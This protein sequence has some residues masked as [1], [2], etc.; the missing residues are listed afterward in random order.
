MEAQWGEAEQEYHLVRRALALAYV[1]QGAFA[2]AAAELQEGLRVSSGAGE[3]GRRYTGVAGR[4]PEGSEIAQRRS[5][6]T[7]KQ[8]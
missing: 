8:D 7:T 2:K 6:T 1:R 5:K 4:D 3:A